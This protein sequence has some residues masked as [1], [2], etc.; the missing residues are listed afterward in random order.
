MKI[1]LTII[2]WTIFFPLTLTWKFLKWMVKD[3]RPEDMKLTGKNAKSA[4]SFLGKAAVGAFAASKVRQALTPPTIILSNPDYFVKG[5]TP[6]GLTQYHLYV[7]SKRPGDPDGQ[8]TIGK[9]TRS[10]NIGGTNF[11][12]HWA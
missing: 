7:S 9:E 11:T 6:R 10:G 3:D 4:A 8:M 12:A 1:L 5:L 2:K